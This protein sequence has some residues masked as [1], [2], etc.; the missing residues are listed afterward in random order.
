MT[1]RPADPHQ[2]KPPKSIARW[3]AGVVAVCSS[4][5]TIYGLF[6]DK[7]V[8]VF[9]F[10][11]MIIGIVLLVVVQRA[12]RAVSAHDATF[13]DFLVKGLIVFVLLYFMVLTAALFPFLIKWLTS[14]GP[15]VNPVVV[16][17]TPIEDKRSPFQP[18]MFVPVQ[19][20]VLW[21]D[22]R[23]LLTS[24]IPVVTPIVPSKAFQAAR[25]RSFLLISP[26]PVVTPTA[27]PAMTVAP[28][29][30]IPVVTPTAA[31]DEMK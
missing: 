2:A 7:R 4:A 1:R 19:P 8:A 26:I 21:R 16:A 9:G 23:T 13:Y 24:P 18:S 29:F 10:I 6:S 28:P 25:E 30:R 22:H 27:A 5:A 31:P 3:V 17:P 11:G 14:S 12:I 15:P 20:T